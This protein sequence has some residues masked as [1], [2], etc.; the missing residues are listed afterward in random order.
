MVYAVKVSGELA[1]A[2]HNVHYLLLNGVIK[3]SAALDKLFFESL[4][5]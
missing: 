3:H 2:S 4:W 5:L 1:R